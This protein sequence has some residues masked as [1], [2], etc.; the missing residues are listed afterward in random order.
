MQKEGLPLQSDITD[1]NQLTED[2]LLVA[3]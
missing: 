3:A 1:F 2:A